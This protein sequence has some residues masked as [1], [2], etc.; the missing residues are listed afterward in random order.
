MEQ[1]I[2]FITNNYLLVLAFLLAL[3][4]LLWSESKKAGASVSSTEAV[5]LMNKD[6]AVL[7]DIRSKKEWESGSITNSTH[8]PLVDLDKR[9]SEL[10]KYKSRNVIVVCNM[11]QS[12]GTACKKLMAAGFEKVVRLK[13]GITEWKAQNLPLVK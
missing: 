9:L 13:G 5:Q 2:E 1:L 6:N 8:I 3:G 11:G 12:S 4:M 7:L 10:E